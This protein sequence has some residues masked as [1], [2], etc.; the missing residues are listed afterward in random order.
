[1]I[2]HGRNHVERTYKRPIFQRLLRNILA[3]VLPSPVLFKLI[4]VV[5]NIFRP[6]MFLAPSN[7]KNMV[8]FMPKEFPKSKLPYNPVFKPKSKVVSKVALLTGCVQKVISPEINDSSI[9]ILTTTLKDYGFIFRNHPDPKFRKKAKMISK[10]TKDITEYLDESIKLDFIESSKKKKYRV[11]YHSAC[12]MQ[13]GQKV[14]EQPVKLL[15]K[16]GNHIYEI[17]DGHICCGSAGTYNLMQPEIAGELLKRK[18]NN[19]QKINPDFVATGNVGCIKQISMGTKIP[20]LHTIELLDWYTG[21]KKPD[22]I[23]S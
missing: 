14:H 11:A 1:M 21:G 20:I 10:L 9:N 15:N 13:H 5:T 23:K 2:D 12:S 18:V 8:K 4:A 17:P 16:T 22:S 3:I 7:I 6:L 19:I